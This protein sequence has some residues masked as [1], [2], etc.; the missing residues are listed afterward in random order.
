MSNAQCA[1]ACVKKGAKYVFVRDSK[2]YDIDN[3]DFAD[4]AAHAGHNVKLTGEMTGDTIKVSR[5]EMP[6]AKK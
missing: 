5:I 2:V 6:S 4:L 1:T 3:Q